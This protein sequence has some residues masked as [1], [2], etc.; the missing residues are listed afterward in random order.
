MFGYLHSIVT[1]SYVSCSCC[2]FVDNGLMCNHCH[3]DV[4]TVCMQAWY[5]DRDDVALNGF[6]KFFKKQSEEE[7]EHAD[8]LMKYQNMRGGRVVLQNIQVIRGRYS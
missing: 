7:R 6:H 3:V 5:F 4:V 2:I 8:K 1:N